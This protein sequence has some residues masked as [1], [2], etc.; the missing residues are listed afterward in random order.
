ME[1][2][3][4]TVTPV[5]KLEN[6]AA[7]PAF[8]EDLK[9]LKKDLF[10]RK[11]RGS[12][13][14]LKKS[15]AAKKG[16]DDAQA[17]PVEFTLDGSVFSQALD[18]AIAV[19]EKQMADDDLKDLKKQEATLADAD[20]L[21]LNEAV[22][23]LA[24]ENTLLRSRLAQIKRCAMDNLSELLQKGR[25]VFAQMFDII[26][27]KYQ[28]DID[29]VKLLVLFIKDRIEAELKLE[30]VQFDANKF[31]IPEEDYANLMAGLAALNN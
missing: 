15:T 10:A 12:N 27:A 17:K 1:P 6:D 19:V 25:D 2:V 3:T 24:A 11:R 20:K 4:K 31:W 23:A 22:E 14:N 30:D 29:A 7:I 9:K 18:A 16:A 8:F 21:V 26:G 13:S 5:P 28:Q